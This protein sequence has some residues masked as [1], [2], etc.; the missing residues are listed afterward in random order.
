[1][2]YTN[3]Y[4]LAT[5]SAWLKHT[6]PDTEVIYST[7]PLALAKC[8]E[9]WCTAAS[10]AWNQVHRLGRTIVGFGKR[11]LVGGHHA[12]A[13]PHSLRYGEAFVGRLETYTHLDELPLPDWSIFPQVRRHVMM[14][15]RGCPFDCRFCSSKA[16]WRGYQARGAEM[17]TR[18]I[19]ML[20]RMGA[21]DII[22]F[23]DL[24]TANKQRLRAVVERVEAEKLN[25]ITFSCLVRS[26]TA[27][28]EVIELLQRMNVKSL[29]FGAES[30]SDRVLSLMGKKA[31]V[32]D[33]QRAID[34]LVK[35]GFAPTMGLIAGFPG[36]QWEDLQQTREF[37]ARN[38]DQCAII[39]IYP[40]IPF[41]GTAIWEPFVSRYKIDVLNFTWD[42][43]RIEPQCYNHD[44][45]LSLVD[46]DKRH[47][48][49]LL[50]WNASEKARKAK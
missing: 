24:F 13:L 50:E 45:Y 25:Y 43:L 18:E 39:D 26:D 8:D 41:P 48:S 6:C 46:Y 30:G 40:C 31:T 3:S 15:S 2:D 16:F 32:A 35:H 27:D 36:E 38:R 37:V 10:E 34:L 23:D 12:T 33:N 49:D 28:E 44:R 21:Q 42:V 17:V 7:D 29:A 14:T 22:L 20:R 4:T 47:I 9:V 5:I 1:V 19:H 11:F